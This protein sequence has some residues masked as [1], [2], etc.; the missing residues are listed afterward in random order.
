MLSMKLSSQ[1]GVI[2]YSWDIW[3]CLETVLFVT[4]GWR[5]GDTAGIKWVESREAAKLPT[6]VIEQLQAIKNY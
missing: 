5:R 6:A 1:L 2:L 4:S 3:Q